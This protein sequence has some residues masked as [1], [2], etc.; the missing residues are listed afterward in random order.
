MQINKF[1]IVL[2]LFFIQ[3]QFTEAQTK[4]GFIPKEYVKLTDEQVNSGQIMITPD[5]LIF[6]SRGQLLSQSEMSLM[7][8][9]DYRPLFFANSDGNIKALVFE[10]KSDNPVLIEKNPE[11]N[12][13]KG[14]FAKDFIVKDL[15]GNNI[16]L[17]ELRGKVV[18]LKFW[19]LKCKPCIE[20]IPHL[21]KLKKEYQTN[22]VEFLAITFDKKEMVEQFLLNIPFNYKI[23][24]NAMDAIRIHGINSFPTNMVI[25]QKGEIVLKEIGYR[26]NI[27]EVLKASIDALLK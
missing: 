18:V 16:K 2:L 23:A 15:K 7:A 4:Y 9:P 8:N 25:N 17:S 10:R 14:E 3:V 21:N 22:N 5:V 26:T 11:A 12:F 24:S 27:T 6:S 13:H 1:H 19:F 20:E